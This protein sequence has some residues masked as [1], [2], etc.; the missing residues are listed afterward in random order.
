MIF[1]KSIFLIFLTL[2]NVINEKIIYCYCLA[3]QRRGKALWRTAPLDGTTS[4]LSKLRIWVPLG[5]E[6]LA[7]DKS[8]N[9]QLPAAFN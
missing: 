5:L 3:R 9:P 7:R 4:V 8:P 2:N 1:V 6:V